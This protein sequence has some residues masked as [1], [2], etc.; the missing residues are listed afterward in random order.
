[1]VR[2]QDSS[3]RA[4][5]PVPQLASKLTDG[6]CPAVRTT[7][8]TAP[9]RTTIMT[10]DVSNPTVG[11]QTVTVWVNGLVLFSIVMPTLGGVSWCG[12][13]VIEFAQ[14]IEIIASSTS[15]D[16]HVSG[17]ISL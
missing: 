17:L 11:A 14:T 10:I 7:I 13:Q 16:Y 3:M 5:P 2:V 9:S 12:P 6:A 4:L 1:M 15:C 8:F